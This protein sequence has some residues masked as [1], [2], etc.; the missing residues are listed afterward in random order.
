MYANSDTSIKIDE[1]E[2]IQQQKK[3][4]KG[5]VKD[6]SGLPL[7]GVNVYNKNSSDGT[8]T[9]LY[10]AFVVEAKMGDEI[11]FSYIGY[12]P[13][14]IKVSASTSTLNIVLKEDT[15]VLEEVVVTALGIKRQK[16][17]LGYSTTSVG[18]EEFT[19]DRKST[20]LNSSH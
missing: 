9:D 19:Q 1:V 16:R 18:G 10:G 15:E 20:R 3:S 8:I 4:I 11:D 2:L 12:A 17:A 14:S 13:Q 5:V 6:E 7:I